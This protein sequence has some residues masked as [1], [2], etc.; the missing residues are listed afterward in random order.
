MSLTYLIHRSVAMT[1]IAGYL[2]GLDHGHRVHEVRAL[3]K[4]DQERLWSLAATAPPL[5]L[6]HFVPADVPALREVI[7]HGKNSLPVFTEFQKRMCR[8]ADGEGRLFGYN[9]GITRPLLGPGCFVVHPTADTPSWG[10]RGAMVVDYW[11]VPDG[12]VDPR[13]PKVVG[14]HVGLQRLVYHQT[15]DFMRGVSA[16][17]SIGKAWKKEK[18]MPAYFVL[19]RE[20]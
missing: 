7:H 1:D 13:W 14:N 6:E 2:D 19:C 4:K 8:P 11:M 5:T 3:E 20:D 15:R 18:A 16:H 10:P 12:P 17:V 9:E